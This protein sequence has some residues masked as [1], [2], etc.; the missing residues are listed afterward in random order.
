VSCCLDSMVYCDC[1]VSDH[2]YCYVNN[3]GAILLLRYLYN[4]ESHCSDGC[5]GC[6]TATCMLKSDCQN[7]Q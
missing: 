4:R 5:A 3:F 2:I 1:V 6:S 7:L